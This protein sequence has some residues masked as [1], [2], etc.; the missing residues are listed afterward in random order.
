MIY[1]FTYLSGGLRV[2]GYA[3]LPPEL[4][5]TEEAFTGFL[6]REFNDEEL[7]AKLVA[8]ILPSAMSKPPRKE[9][10]PVLVYC[11]GG[12]GRVG[13]VRL[14]WL[15]EFA[16]FGRIVVAPCYRGGES[17]VG[18]DRFGGEDLED[19][20]VAMRI[21]RVFPQADPKRIAVLGFSRGSINATDAAIEEH[22]AQLVLWGGLSD[23]GRTYEERIDLRKML[24]RVMNGSVY[25]IPEAYM[26]RSPIHMARRLSCPVLIMHGTEDAQ[27]EY[28]HGERMYEELQRLGKTTELMTLDGLGHH[29]PQEIRLRVLNDMFDWLDRT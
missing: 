6:R 11:R 13:K 1:R 16:S 9:P 10:Y 2:A 15:A 12:I 7:S 19:S 20:R 27:V 17:G 25:K 5:F 18:H 14:D 29:M 24:K 8:C 4:S 23:L 22:A 28:G 26:E 21:A 3:A